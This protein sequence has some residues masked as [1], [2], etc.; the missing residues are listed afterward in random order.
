MSEAGIKLSSWVQKKPIV[1][2]RFDKQDSEALHESRQGFE[3]LTIARPHS[4]LSNFK[5]PTICLVEI[6]CDKDRLLKLGVVTKK[7]AVSTLD[8][9]LTIK[10]L[11]DVLPS[12][13]QKIK[14]ALDTTRMKTLFASGIAKRKEFSL[15]SPKLSKDIIK[16]LDL[17]PQ[18]RVSLETALSVLPGLREPS[19]NMWAQ[20]D[21]IE[22][23]LE[24]FGLR[25]NNADEI[26]VKRDSD[27]GLAFIGNAHLYEDNVV[28]LEAS[29]LPGFEKISQSV[30]G[31]ATFRKGDEQLTIYT[32]N[33]LPLEE[34]LGVD[35]IY[36]HETRGNIVMIQ[37]KMLE[38]DDT[39]EW[40]FRLDSKCL[41]EIDRMQLPKIKAEITD[42]RLHRS[43]FYFKFVKRKA[44][45][46]SS[47][48]FLISLEHFQQLLN[49]P[50]VKGPKGGV[51][52]SYKALNGIYLRQAD[53]L[54]LIRSGY[55]GTHRV[56]TDSLKLIIEEVA[57][58]NRAVVLAWQRAIHGVSA[59]TEE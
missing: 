46:D 8:S 37:Y 39:E 24:I 11:R 28:H 40:I 9:R 58:G 4:I 6:Y 25:M 55:I 59:L 54:G 47:Q 38:A 22:S 15:L 32:A 41:D 49:S 44:V 34:M 56:E 2:I 52:I 57:S 29:N 14:T 18:N 36:I 33:K 35:L 21:A 43:P 10:K 50:I 20:E 19:S 27:S 12:S 23:A 45:N 1:L 13:L 7:S 53:I 48:S 17:E 51:R 42:Y 5:L 3:H 16:V 30:T 31:K 26:L